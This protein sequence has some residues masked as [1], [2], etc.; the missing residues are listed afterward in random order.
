[1]FVIGRRDKISF[2]NV[3][4][5]FS[6]DIVRIDSLSSFYP[7]LHVQRCIAKLYTLYAGTRRFPP[8]RARGFLIPI[9]CSSCNVFDLHLRTFGS[10]HC[11]FWLSA[12]H[13]IFHTWCPHPPVVHA[14]VMFNNCVVCGWILDR[15]TSMAPLVYFC[16]TS[17]TLQ[18]LF[19][20][21]SLSTEFWLAARQFSSSRYR[22]VTKGTSEQLVS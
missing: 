9:Y 5:L 15:I 16:D 21:V 10:V 7:I 6:A 8:L 2:L 13:L 1:M 11:H 12:R 17:R 22:A 20:C 19:R 4:L 3:T 14:R 18:R